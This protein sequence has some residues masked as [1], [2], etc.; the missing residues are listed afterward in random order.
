MDTLS[1][2][3]VN[4]KTGQQLRVLIVDDSPFI[5]KQLS[6]ILLSA[7]IEVVGT[8]ENGFVGLEKFKML[9]EAGKL[10]FVTLDITMPQ[11]DGYTTLEE[12][13]EINKDACIIMVTA[14]GTA[15]MVKKCLLTGAKGYILKPFDR[16]KVLERIASLFA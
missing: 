9:T 14:L 6:H 12:M 1:K 3:I 13:L 2:R 16:E 11:K 4:G 5:I 8:A 15:E 7:D 10:D